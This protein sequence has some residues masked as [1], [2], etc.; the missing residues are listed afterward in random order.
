M[1]GRID[2]PGAGNIL[3]PAGPLGFVGTER[4]PPQPAPV[5]GQD[6]DRVLADVLGLSDSQ[7]GKLHDAGA[8][9]GPETA[10]LKKN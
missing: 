6:T 3:A 5:L 1:F 10:D 8:V 9:A 2:Q 7:I 4:V